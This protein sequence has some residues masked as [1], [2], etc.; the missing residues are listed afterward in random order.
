VC[1][2]VCVCPYPFMCLCVGVKHHITIYTNA[3]THTHSLTYSGEGR[4]HECLR[5]H[6]MELSPECRKEELLLE[7]MEAVRAHNA[8]CLCNAFFDRR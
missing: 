5:S 1:V 7:E 4:I 2:C 8:H 3:Y 6:R